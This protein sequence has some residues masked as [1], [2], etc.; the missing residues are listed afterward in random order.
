[1]NDDEIHE[2]FI[3]ESGALSGKVALVP[4]QGFVLGRSSDCGLFPPGSTV[5]RRHAHVFHDRGR[6]VVSDLESHNGVWINSKRAHHNP[7]CKRGLNPPDS[8]SDRAM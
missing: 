3:V 8:S 6:T 2:R 7:G 5:S 4:S 1:V